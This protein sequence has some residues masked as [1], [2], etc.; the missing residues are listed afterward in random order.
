MPRVVPLPIVPAFGAALALA[1]LSITSGASALDCDQRLVA[2]GDHALQVRERCGEPASVSARTETRTELAGTRGSA[3]RGSAFSVT[4]AIEVWVYDF[5]PRRFMEELT[6]ENG[7]LRSMRP[8]G[9]GTRAGSE[10]RTAVDRERPER[11]AIVE[12]R[13]RLA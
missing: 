1:L 4:V 3:F 10:R 11:L 8:L 5:G 2:V 7:I 12:R 9:Y 6:F 13:R